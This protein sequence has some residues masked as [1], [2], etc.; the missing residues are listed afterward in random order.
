MENPVFHKELTAPCGMNCGVCIAYLRE[1]KPCPGCRKRTE[2]K[3]KHCITCKIANCEY[4][5]E[6]ESKFCFECRKFPCQRI[7]QLDLRYRKN[8][9]ISLIENLGQI[10]SNGIEYF[11]QLQTLRHICP[12]CQNILSVHRNFCLHCKVTINPV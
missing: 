5:E 12:S 2:N 8:Y 4:L 3:P 10:Q 1:K 9:R 6:T 11:L 7:K